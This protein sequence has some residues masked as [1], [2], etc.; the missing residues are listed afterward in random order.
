MLQIR[1]R[2]VFTTH[3]PCLGT[4]SSTALDQAHVVRLNHA[5]PLMFGVLALPVRLFGGGAGV[6]IGVGLV[7]AS[8]T[9]T[10]AVLLVPADQVASE[11]N[12]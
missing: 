9:S 10:V 8:A 2:D 3:H 6:A 12:Q 1:A 7:N 11:S 4:A 5:G